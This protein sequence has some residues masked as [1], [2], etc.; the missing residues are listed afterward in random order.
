MAKHTDAQK[1]AAVKRSLDR[2][3]ALIAERDAATAG[4][5]N[6]IR[7]L[8]AKRD[9]IAKTFTKRVARIEDGIIRRTLELGHSVIGA[10]AA[11]RYTKGYP[12]VTYDRKSLDGYAVEHPAILAF[13]KE[14]EVKAR[15]SI[16]SL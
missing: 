15:C 13:R 11:A 5:D 9:A 3:T 4:I 2:W 6:E 8:Q 16:K 7:C 1:Y 12:R 14:T 10:G